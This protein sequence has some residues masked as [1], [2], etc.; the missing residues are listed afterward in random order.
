MTFLRIYLKTK[1]LKKEIIEETPTIVEA[2]EKLE[3]TKPLAIKTPPKTEK[4]LSILDQLKQEAAAIKNIKLENIK[5]SQSVIEISDDETVVKANKVPKEII[6][7][8]DSDD[9]TKRPTTPTA[10]LS[11]NQSPRQKTK[12]P[13]Q[14]TP[15]KNHEI[16]EFFDVNY[17][18]KR[19]PDKPFQHH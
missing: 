2:K 19:T 4:M 1:K 13:K 12:S 7:I 14:K 3:E 16:T 15:S 8:C 5:L 10:Q 18:V 6:E 11:A 9:N 17:V